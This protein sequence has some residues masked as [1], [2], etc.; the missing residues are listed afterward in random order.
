M[1]CIPISYF[2]G[3]TFA[4]ITGMELGSERIT[5]TTNSGSS[6]VMIHEQD[7][8]ET[9]LV[10]DV[11]GDYLDLIDTPILEASERSEHKSDDP[12][13]SESSTWTFYRITTIKGT[14]VLR[15]LGTSNGYYS[16]G[17]SIAR[18]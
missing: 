15:W 16:E 3:K 7:C 5:F 9:V 2:I 12:E 18:I 13:S 4:S 6:F 1:E 11:C 14:V 8:C 17:V 10:E